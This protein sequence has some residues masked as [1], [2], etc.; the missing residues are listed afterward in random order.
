M[1]SSC[2]SNVDGYQCDICKRTFAWLHSLKDHKLT[3]T[4][5]RKYKCD[6]CDKAFFK[7]RDLLRHKM[8]HNPMKPYQCDFCGKTFA[9]LQYLQHCLL[10][11][12]R[13]V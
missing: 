1:H 4:G 8:I 10:Y 12:S 9:L 13:C 7:P 11:T 2:D 6:V 3:H 5:I